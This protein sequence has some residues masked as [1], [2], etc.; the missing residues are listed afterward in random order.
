MHL[1]LVSVASTTHSV[2]VY[3][4]LPLDTDPYS[5]TTSDPPVPNGPMFDPVMYTVSPPAVFN[6]L[7]PVVGFPTRTPVTADGTWVM[8]F[9]DA[10]LV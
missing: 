5:T 6:T 9:V 3:T 1:T 7:P 4:G 2:A 8:V 10:A